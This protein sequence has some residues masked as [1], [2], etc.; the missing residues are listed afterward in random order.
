MRLCVGTADIKAVPDRSKRL[1][2]GLVRQHRVRQS[3]GS[4]V[5]HVYALR[6]QPGSRNGTPTRRTPKLIGFVRTMISV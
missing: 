5:V 4:T 1:T 3:H 6:T 2:T